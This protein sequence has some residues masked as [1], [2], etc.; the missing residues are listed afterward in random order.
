MAEILSQ[1]EIEALLASLSSDGT[2]TTTPTASRSS[3]NQAK[4][5]SL[6]EPLRRDQRGPI[7]YEI[8]DF[9]RPDKFAKD[10]LRTL[11]MLHETF[12]RLYASSLSAYLRVP[13]HVDL[14][15]VEQVPYEEYIRSLS[16]S[17]INVFSMA[18]LAGQAI[19]EVELNV[20][21][22]MI[23]RLLGGPGSVVK[24]SS[25][26][27]DIEKA[28][29]DSIINRALKDFRTAWE[30]IAQF[31]PKRETMETQAQFVQI[32]PPNDVVVSILFEVKVGE[33]RGAMSIC[34]PYLLLKPITG[35]LSAQRWFSSSLRK[36]VGRHAPVLAQRLAK[37]YLTCVVRLGST[38][39][40]VQ[41]LLELKEG[42][43]VTLS[44]KQ[45]EEVEVLIG[46]RVKFRAQPGVRG[47]KLAIHITRVEP[48]TEQEALLTHR[49]PSSRRASKMKNAV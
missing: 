23:D 12:A 39:M 3:G 14:V 16:S 17:I 9:R 49:S 8:Y 48:A 33:L 24:S 11:Q 19:L 38:Q 15:S 18:P 7:A 4:P 2:E 29:T 31:N 44:R 20:I 21:L 25:V 41:Q 34:I 32:V 30:G 35:K 22:C 28:L 42:D 37:T 40:T 46:D 6:S 10:Q 43:I 1:E 27:T 45:N 36:N 47:K 26:L 13:V 5:S